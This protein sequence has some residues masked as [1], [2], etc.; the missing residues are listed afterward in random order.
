MLLALPPRV[1]CGPGSARARPSFLHT[2][3][4]MKDHTTYLRNNEAGESLYHYGHKL[5]ECRGHKL[6][7]N[8]DKQASSFVNL[9]ELPAVDRL[10]ADDRVCQAM[11]F[12]TWRPLTAQPSWSVHLLPHLS[13]LKH[14]E[15]GS[16]QKHSPSLCQVP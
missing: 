2:P 1:W 14:K 9:S 16:W 6:R 12:T 10:K 5:K 15:L 11:P 13:T 4:T 3:L 7:K 8:V